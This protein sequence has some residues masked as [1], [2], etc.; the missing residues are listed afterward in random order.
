MLK[1]LDIELQC[2]IYCTRN[3]IIGK[4]LLVY[5]LGQTV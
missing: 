1:L 3:L 4:D 5:F 2:A